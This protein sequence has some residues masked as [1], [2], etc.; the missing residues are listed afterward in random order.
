MVFVV[1]RGRSTPSAVA[2]APVVVTLA[3]H[4][5]ATRF[6]LVLVGT[7]ESFLRAAGEEALDEIERLEGQLSR[8]RP[9]SEIS[10]INAHAAAR[11]VPLE[12]RLF[13]LLER[14]QALSEATDGAFDP[15]L[16]PL[17]ECWSATTGERPDP[18]RLA[19][20]RARVGIRAVSL[21]PIARTIRFP[22]AGM[23]LD[24]GAIGKGYAI[25]RAVELL[26]QAGVAA[27]LLHGG[28][29]TAYG[30][31]APP[32][33]AGWRVAVREPLGREGFVASVVLRDRALSVSAGHGRTLGSAGVAHVLD[34]RS[35][36]P[37]TANLLAA[38]L[39]PS[40]TDTDALSTALLV[41]GEAG[42]AGVVAAAGDGA[43][44]VVVR[45]GEGS[46][47]VHALGWPGGEELPSH[48]APGRATKGG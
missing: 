26:R 31:G 30:L 19:A 27:A 38:V 10:G 22:Q 5:M 20:A 48:G 12:P 3:R 11:P 23:A 41:L 4:A 16:A 6:E 40:A 21:D 28:T 13:A 36:E 43:A 8:F 47:R 33:A 37:V 39:A 17:L 25:D 1:E 15:T 32:G 2:G 24:L 35:G 7:D 46:P 9:E 45:D 18:A 44:L 29:S 34:P 42:L 14:A